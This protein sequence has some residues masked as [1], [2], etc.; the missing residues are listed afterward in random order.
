MDRR[1]PD[2]HRRRL[3]GDQVNEAVVALNRSCNALLMALGASLFRHRSWTPIPFL[4][5]L[6]FV[7]LHESPDAIT[8]IPGL[9]L[10]LLGEGLRIWSVAVI[11]KESRTRGGTAARLVSSGPYAYVRNP[12][13]VGNLMLT[14]GATLISELLWCVPV[15]VLLFL[16]QYVPIVCWEEQVLAERFGDAYRAYCHQVPR[17]LPRCHPRRDAAAKATYQWRAAWWSERSTLGTLALLLVMMLLKENLPHLPDYLQKHHPDLLR[18]FQIRG[19]K[20]G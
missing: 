16:I 3:V 17:W 1:I 18:Y 6:T 15:V 12:L 11:G 20:A 9:G 4:L 14:L 19:S 8:W 13:Y 10:L 5:L 2:D 7:T